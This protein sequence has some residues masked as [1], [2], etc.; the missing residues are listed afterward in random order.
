LISCAWVLPSRLI[1]FWS[2][3]FI[4]LKPISCKIKLNKVQITHFIK[5]WSLVTCLIFSTL[6]LR[7]W[8]IHI[9][10]VY[11]I[12]KVWWFPQRNAFVQLFEVWS[13]QLLFH[14]TPFFLKEW[15]TENL[16]LFQL[17][18]LTFLGRKPQ[19]M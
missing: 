13:E 1:L 11:S 7:K 8:E 17:R 6:H 9:K 4:F 16:W 18:Y 2:N 12:T 19:M 14:K 15:W 10:H 5:S 3:L